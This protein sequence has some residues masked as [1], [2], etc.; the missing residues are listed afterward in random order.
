[1]K[2]TIENN[3]LV[4]AEP[5]GETEVVIPD[6]VTRI[7]GWAFKG[8]DSLTSVNIPNSVTQIE[9]DAF[10]NCESLLRFA[11]DDGNAYYATANG[12][13][14]DKEK[15]TLLRYPMGRTDAHYEIPD[16]VTEI[17]SRAFRDCAALTSVNMPGGLTSIGEGAFLDCVALTS[18]N[19]PAGVTHIGADAFRDCAALT[20]VTIP[21]GVTKIEWFTFFRCA[22]LKSITIPGGVTHIGAD[23]FRDCA[24]LT[25]VNISEG[26]TEIDAAVF[27]G[28]T[29]LEI[30]NIPD[31]VTDIWNVEFENCISLKSFVVG[32][33]NPSYSAE[34]GVLFDKEKRSLIC[35]PKGKKDGAYRIPDGVARIGKGA[36]RDCVALTSVTIPDSVTS[37]G[38]WA[39]RDCVA[40]TNVTIPD[41]VTS[42]GE[43]AFLCCNALTSV[44]IPDGVKEIN[45]GVF[46]GC[47]A[48]TNVII[49]AG[50]T[51][52][53]EYAFSRCNALTSVNIPD[54][55]INFKGNAFLECKNLAIFAGAGLL[56][57]LVPESRIHAALGYLVKPDGHNEE[58]A[59]AYAKY[60]KSHAKN[61][62]E[63]I[64]DTD[65]VPAMEGYAKMIGLSA[66]NYDSVFEAAK[67]KGAGQIMAFLSKYR[68]TK[69]AAD[70]KQMQ[71]AR[72]Q[73]REQDKPEA[74]RQKAQRALYKTYAASG[75]KITD[76]KL[77]KYIGQDTHISIPD[78]VTE[79]GKAAFRG[80][81]FVTHITV[82][83]GVARIGERA[84]NE[85]AA[86]RF[87][88]LP[89][90]L[91]SIGRNA[92]S[93][94]TSLENITLPKNVTALEYGLF[95]YCNNLKE[96]RCLGDI[97]TVGEEAFEGCAVAEITAYFAPELFMELWLH[98]FY[99]HA[100]RP[101]RKAAL[102]FIRRPEAFAGKD[103]KH[104]VKYC[105]YCEKELLSEIIKYDDVEAILNYKEIVGRIPINANN[106]ESFL[107]VAQDAKA[108]QSVAYLLDYR[109]Q[110]ISDADMEAAENKK[111]D[112][113]I[114]ASAKDRERENKLAAEKR[115]QENALAAE[116]EE[117]AAKGLAPVIEAGDDYVMVKFDDGKSYKYSCPFK[118]KVGDRVKVDGSRNGQVGVV[119][120]TGLGAVWSE[121]RYMQ[122]VAR[123]YSAPEQA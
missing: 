45:M 54:G 74:E 15:K 68:D 85:C 41:S 62:L 105:K 51:S 24:A 67:Q 53:D 38:E 52:I 5:N 83:E 39:F 34:D 44:N 36:F 8:C 101:E 59:A 26:V 112:K 43:W 40:L 94:C 78:V 2:L 99:D 115:E 96:L 92:F 10:L 90:S 46:N 80:L 71:A 91:V 77:T 4:K 21:N 14:F 113:A 7:D 111:R 82:P 117:M 98:S 123:A 1:M 95:R 57:K 20:N 102:S 12:V 31:S 29:S 19:I 61:L 121:R 16:G 87:V 56:K 88:A 18:V 27:K 42:I 81:D 110:N 48:L 17:G 104:Y 108:A 103:C 76:G 84:F 73:E 97:S 69:F 25:S 72:K 60:C 75:F 100:T 89:D 63:L 35:Y 32:E 64:L 122:S 30:I 120:E 47:T 116:R 119:A 22:A 9:S 33:R 37:I 114:K 49:P 55:V 28:C 109:K 106:F 70:E 86:L 3:V 107:S 66:R 11:V 58:S 79:I 118:V 23:A 13:L 6:G 93:G 50:V 65:N